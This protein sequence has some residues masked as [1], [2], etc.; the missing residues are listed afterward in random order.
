VEED[1]GDGPMEGC[2]PALSPFRM[3]GRACLRSGRGGGWDDLGRWDWLGITSSKAAGTES[4][5]VGKGWTDE[6]GTFTK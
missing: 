1:G 4:H 5:H 2:G 6:V 3:V